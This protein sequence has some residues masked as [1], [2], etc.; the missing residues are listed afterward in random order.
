M[1]RLYGIKEANCVV[2]DFFCDVISESL[3][4]QR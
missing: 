2:D 4:P 3:I 1:G